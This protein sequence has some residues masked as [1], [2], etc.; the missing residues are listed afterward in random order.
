MPQT[1]QEAFASQVPNLPRFRRRQAQWLLNLPD[2]D[3]HKEQ[4]LL[5]AEDKARR[6]L[7]IDPDVEVDWTEG[8]TNAGVAAPI[9]WQTIIAVL[10]AA[11]PAIM[12][13]FGC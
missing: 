9:N 6:H 7:G 13:M 4:A 8:A 10:M 2:D 5:H 3:P 11:L 12:K 1:F